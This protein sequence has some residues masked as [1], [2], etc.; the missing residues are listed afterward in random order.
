MYSFGGDGSNLSNMRAGTI[1]AILLAA[2]ACAQA[3]WLSYRDPTTPRLKDGSANLSAPVPRASNGKPDLSG[4]WQVEATPAAE[5]LRLFG[6]VTAFSVPG[7]D[8]FTFSKYM[9]NLL[10]DFKPEDSPLRPDAAERYLKLRADRGRE[11]PAAN[12]LPPGLPAADLSPAPNKIVQTPGMLF[13]MYE[14]FGGHRQIYTD[15]RK[16][17][18]DPDPLW[19]GYSV[20]RWEGDT[21]AVDT[22]GFNDKTWLDAFGH[23]HSEDLHLVERFRRRDFGH[24]DVQVTLNDPKTFTRPFTVKFTWRLIPDS[25]VGEYFCAENEKDKAHMP[26]P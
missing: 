8:V 20:G 13:I 4:V 17:P 16:L 25:D 6:D 7:D 18:A 26:K 11:S 10:S 14:V 1:I 21:L 5:M 2:A 22:I 24:M 3:Q 15:G 23:P 12:C 19:L 9:F